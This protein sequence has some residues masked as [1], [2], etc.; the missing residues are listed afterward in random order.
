MR[1]RGRTTTTMVT[2]VRTRATRSSS[3]SIASATSMRT[4][5]S[6]SHFSTFLS[7]R[8]GE[9]PSM[10]STCCTFHTMWMK[11]FP[12][13]SRNPT[14]LRLPRIG[15]L[16]VSISSLSG[17]KWSRNWKDWVS[18]FL[19]RMRLYR[20]WRLSCFFFFFKT[21]VFC[22]YECSPTCVCVHYM[23]A[24]HMETRRGY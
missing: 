21:Y 12:I 16:A 18:R 2:L 20:R 9:T 23:H 19:I 1:R 24:V 6:M 14:S 10:R 3:A 7:I 22:V 15:A 17:K 13:A 11:W 4:F 5:I 8:S